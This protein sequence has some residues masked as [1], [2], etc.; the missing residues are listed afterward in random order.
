MITLAKLEF[1]HIC[2]EHLIIA[3]SSQ[4]RAALVSIVM[5]Y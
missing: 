5:L 3:L 1:C 2:W 4:R